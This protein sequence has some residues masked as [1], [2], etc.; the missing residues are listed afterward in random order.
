MTIDYPFAAQLEGAEALVTYTYLIDETGQIAN[1][2]ITQLLGEDVFE[3]EIIEWLE[4]K[5][6]SPALLN[7]KRIESWELQ[8]RV[9][10]ID[11]RTRGA[12]R[13]FVVRWK[14]FIRKL[15]EGDYD[16]ANE[17]ML[18]M[19]EVSDRSLYEEL[20]LQHA[21]A[22][23]ALAQAE[24]SKAYH[25]LQNLNSLMIYPFGKQGGLIGPADLYYNLL[26]EKYQIEAELLLLGDAMVTRNALRELSPESENTL[27]VEE[28]LAGLLEMVS[29]KEYQVDAR[30]DS[31]IYSNSE[32]GWGTWLASNSFTLSNVEGRLR[33]IILDCDGGQLLLETSEGGPLEVPKG[34]GA[35]R[36]ILLGDLGTTLKLSQRRQ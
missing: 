12:R 14:R 26:L 22:T 8:K 36:L 24:R 17:Y 1:I 23:L 20:Y 6:F 16:A 15:G 21:A 10:L 9:F 32:G 27:I 35:C 25:H 11:G 33:R 19:E 34:W 7:G 28:H 29:G 13:N 31:S 3:S 30:L 18:K 5:S 2:Q 4:K